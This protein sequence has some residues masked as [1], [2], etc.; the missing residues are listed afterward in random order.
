MNDI[1]IKAEITD[2]L[3]TETAKDVHAY[4]I[5]IVNNLNTILLSKQQYGN[6]NNLEVVMNRNMQNFIHFVTKN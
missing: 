5:Q 4:L 6:F 3:C 1:I 2:D